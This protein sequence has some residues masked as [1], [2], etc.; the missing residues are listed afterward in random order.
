MP[1]TSRILK[2][3][4]RRAQLAAILT[5][6]LFVPA[7]PAQDLPE[8]PGKDLLQNVCTQCHTLNRIIEKKATKE[9]WNDTVDKMA[10]KGARA[11]DEEFDTIVNYLVKNYGKE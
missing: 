9:E 8:G 3:I 6:F 11:S 5:P 7:A 1:N 4:V 2:M 10:A